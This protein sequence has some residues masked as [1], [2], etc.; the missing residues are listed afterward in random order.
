MD[1]KR[2]RPTGSSVTDAMKTHICEQMAAGR[3]VAHIVNDPEIGLSY[4]TINRELHIDPIFLSSYARAR[5]AG[6]EPK[7]EENESIL[8]GVGEW[9]NVPWDARKEIVNNRRWEAIRLQRYRYGEKTQVDINGT[10]DVDYKV[11]DA[12]VLDMDQREAVRQALY[13][14]LEAPEGEG[15]DE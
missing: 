10:L 11:I 13:A 8:M 4:R 2:G 14:A 1:K 3:S 12:S 9:A 5:E 15:E 7:I 6:I